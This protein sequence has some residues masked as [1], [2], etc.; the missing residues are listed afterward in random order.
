MAEIKDS[1]IV[2]V[3]A[4]K[5]CVDED[6]A[7][8]CLK[9]SVTIDNEFL[10]SCENHEVHLGKWALKDDIVTELIKKGCDCC[11]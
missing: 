7:N 1:D 10:V 4:C 11:G 3:L 2:Q 8:R 5:L 9:V 6:Y